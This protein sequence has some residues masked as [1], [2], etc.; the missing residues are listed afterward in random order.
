M[1]DAFVRKCMTAVSASY[2]AGTEPNC[3]R[4]RGIKAIQSMIYVW[5]NFKF[6][7]LHKALHART[8][9]ICL[10]WAIRFNS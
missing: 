3:A 10:V 8:F 9:Q 1:I 6:R 5:Y 4:Q 7:W 2:G